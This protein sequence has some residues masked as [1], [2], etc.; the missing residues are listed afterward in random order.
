VVFAGVDGDLH[1][2]TKSGGS[3][4][5]AF[6]HGLSGVAAVQPAAT[7]LGSGVLAL[8]VD[9]ATSELRATQRT[10]N[11]WT[12]PVPI[13]GSA[14][15]APPALVALPGGQ[16]LAAWLDVDDDVHTAV[17][18][19][20][21]WSAGAPLALPNPPIICPPALTAGASGADAELV[22]VDAIGASYWMRLSGG[23]WTAPALAGTASAPSC[24]AIATAP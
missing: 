13:V 9:G 16:A 7:M 23:I 21:T 1:D 22:F 18:D 3:W 2:Q 20:T 12:P 8:Y 6:A 5:P 17:F 14:T 15:L 4:Q 11:G 19:G 24:G 10:M